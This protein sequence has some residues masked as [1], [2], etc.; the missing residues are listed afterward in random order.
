MF[1]IVAI[2]M[3]WNRSTNV[4][5]TLAISIFILLLIKPMFIFDVGFQ[6]SYLAVIAIVAIQ[7]LLYKLWKPKFKPIDFL[8]KI[9]TVTIAAQFG[10][11][12]ISLYYFHQFPS[13]FFIS[14][15]VII[16]FLGIILALGII[17]IFLALLN[18]LPE[19][20][21]SLYGNIISIMNNV[22]DWVSSQEQFLFK[23][24]S[25]SFL[26]VIMSYVLMVTL[27]RLYTKKDFNNLCLMLTSILLFQG[28]LLYKSYTHATNSFIIF[29]K[30][31][32]T[33][34]GEKNHNNLKIY[35]NFN[36]ITSTNDNVIKNFR[37]GNFINE[38]QYD[39]IKN[40]YL[41]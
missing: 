13:L 7:P 17:V 3:N 5:N 10:V 16:P 15:L 36:S 28:A 12:P 32:F 29:H 2:A 14:N 1:S 21:A 30:S 4:Y 20:L 26:M 34:I 18:R 38:I 8:W 22:V 24:I 39:T 40:I 25:I 6:L 27:V 11:V 35:H 19:F 23:D 9:F 41:V 31:R 37:V 33:L